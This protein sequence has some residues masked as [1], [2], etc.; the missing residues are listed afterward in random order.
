MDGHSAFLSDTGFIY[1]LDRSGTARAL[2]CCF[3]VQAKIG[4]PMTC[5][6]TGTCPERQIVKIRNEAV[7]VGS[8]ASNTC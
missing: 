6:N 1:I 5:F 4:N 7:V 8:C 3:C 2:V